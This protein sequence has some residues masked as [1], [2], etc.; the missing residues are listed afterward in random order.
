VIFIN[1][2]LEVHSIE[3]DIKVYIT[4]GAEVSINKVIKLMNQH[5]SIDEIIA[6]LNLS[7][8]DI[9]NATSLLDSGGTVEDLIEEFYSSTIKDGKTTLDRVFIAVQD[10]V[11]SCINL[12]RNNWNEKDSLI[13]QFSWDDI[14]ND[15]TAI[16]NDV[17]ILTS[18]ILIK[19]GYSADQ[20][21]KIYNNPSTH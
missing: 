3:N 13:L 20:L 2:N 11:T 8:T 4:D 7:A 5:K 17:G 10:Y 21:N 16:G 1:H 15:C 6:E 12:V 18:V 9:D 14:V 19:R